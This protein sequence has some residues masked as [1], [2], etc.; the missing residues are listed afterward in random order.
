MKCQG[1]FVFKSVEHV[2]AG[3]FKNSNGDIIKYPAS[4][5][6]A[7]DELQ[8]DGKINDVKFKIPESSTEL[9]NQLRILKPYQNIN[10]EFSINFY[11]NGASIRLIPE[12]VQ[13]IDK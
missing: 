6:L 12:K 3:E 5:R 2:D 13:K 9:V 7:V 8:S 4:Y 1:N 11:S 10:L